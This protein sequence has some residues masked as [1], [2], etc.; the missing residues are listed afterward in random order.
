[1]W[2][3]KDITEKTPQYN[4]TW[5]KEIM[6]QLLN[7]LETDHVQPQIQSARRNLQFRL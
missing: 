1:M 6:S 3:G 7:K 5:R 4:I 2:L